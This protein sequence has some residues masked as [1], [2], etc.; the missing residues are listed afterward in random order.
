MLN[1]GGE[2]DPRKAWQQKERCKDWKVAWQEQ[3]QSHCGWNTVVFV[4]GGM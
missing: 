3:A 1:H 4:G 2:K